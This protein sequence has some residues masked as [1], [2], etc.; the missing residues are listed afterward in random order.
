LKLARWRPDGAPP[1]EAKYVMIVAPHTSNWDLYYLLMFAWYHEVPISWLGK[2]TLFRGVAGPVMRRLGGI[3][4]RR[5]RQSGLVS[6]IADEFA[7]ADR[8]VVIVPPEGT[9]RRA[10]HWKSG[11]YRI[12]REAGVPIV[13]ASLDYE[14][15]LGGVGPVVWTTAD[16][17]ADME[18]IRS[19]Y[20]D[21]RGKY[22]HEASEIR[23]RPDG[24]D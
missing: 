3:P 7:A 21:K 22:P 15:R 20:A 9:R 19:Y 4:V 11:F 10:E 13:C 1:D 12:A 5:D 23:L 2:D 18:I 14:R 8:M 24:V 17:E 6:S 16:E